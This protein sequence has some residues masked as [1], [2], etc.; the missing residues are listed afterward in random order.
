MIA[1]A[2]HANCAPTELPP[3]ADYVDVDALN[4]LFGDDSPMS[5]ALASGTL[6]FDYGDLV[7]EVDTVGTVD[8]RDSE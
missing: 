1:A 3:L 4:T 5:P 2:E 6:E 7:V 8:V